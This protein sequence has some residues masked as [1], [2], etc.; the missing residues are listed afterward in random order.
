MSKKSNAI[1]SARLKK[2]ICAVYAK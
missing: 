1:C 2:R